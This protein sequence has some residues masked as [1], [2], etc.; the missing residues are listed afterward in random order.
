M[1][2]L[3][4]RLKKKTRDRAVAALKSSNGQVTTNPATIPGL[5]AKYYQDLYRSRCP[6]QSSILAYLMRTGI[7]QNLA[8]D[9][10]DL[11]DQSI[12]TKEILAAIKCL[13]TGKSPGR[14][15]FPAE[16]YKSLTS[17]LGPLL[18]DLFNFVLNTGL[19]PPSWR[20]ST[21]VVIPKPGRDPLQPSSYRPISLLNQDY[22]LFSAILVNRLNQFIP[23]YIHS[24]QTGFIPKRNISENI[25]KTLNVLSPPKI[26]NIQLLLQSLDVEKAFDS[27]EP[28]YLLSLLRL[29]GFRHNFLKILQS[30]Y[31]THK[32]Y[33]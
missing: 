12:T 15:G 3:A 22:K 18:V 33:V 32:A 31:Q 29:M 7:L 11:M 14:D 25:G 6:Q 19:L 20:E 5:F 21:I 2:Y 10:R 17:V 1:R 26:H 16:L 8:P 24:D 23:N 27:L 28:Q 13:K 9:H 30:L 4:W